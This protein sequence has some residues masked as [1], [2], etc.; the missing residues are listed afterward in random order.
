MKGGWYPRQGPLSRFCIMMLTA[1]GYW[2]APGPLALS[3][4]TTRYLLVMQA[5][6]AVGLRLGQSQASLHWQG[7]AQAEAAAPWNFDAAAAS[8]LRVGQ[9]RVGNRRAPAGAAVRD[10]GHNSYWHKLAHN[11]D[12]AGITDSQCSA[13][14]RPCRHGPGS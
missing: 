2:T 10:S 6:W 13:Q 12:A 1:A 5:A 4:P 14:H 7:G 3:L 11:H 8:E 9:L